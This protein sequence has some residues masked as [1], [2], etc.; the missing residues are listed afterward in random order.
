MG[1]LN[2]GGYL[3][4]FDQLRAPNAP[5]IEVTVGSEQLSV[6][7]TASSYSTG[8]IDYYCATA[9]AG[10]ASIGAESSSSP[11]TIT[12]LTNGTEYTVSGVV[13]S[14]YG[15]SPSSLSS[16]GTPAQS[17]R[18][19]FGGGNFTARSSRIQSHEHSSPSPPPRMWKCAAPS[20]AAALPGVA[21][22][23]TG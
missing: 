12:G 10:G 11:V 6:A 15:S 17:T 14:E 18:A 21:P 2:K 22:T 3:G 1:K 4:G 23:S 19:L 16:T 5:T 20:S 13:K 7:I 9:V 8:T